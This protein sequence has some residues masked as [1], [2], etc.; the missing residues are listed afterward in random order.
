VQ[1]YITELQNFFADAVKKQQE[2][3]V[4]SEQDCLLMLTKGALGLEELTS[5]R[6]KSLEI[7]LRIH[8]AFKDDKKSQQTVNIQITG[9]D[10]DYDEDNG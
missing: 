4:M 2:Q 7:L 1:R 3:T 10:D 5:S 6:L 8:G 9:M